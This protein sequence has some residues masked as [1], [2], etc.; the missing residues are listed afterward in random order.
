VIAAANRVA[1]LFAWRML[2][3]ELGQFIRQELFQDPPFVFVLLILQELTKAADVLADDPILEHAFPRL[4]ESQFDLQFR[5]RLGPDE[6]RIPPVC[7]GSKANA[8]QCHRSGCGTFP[9][10]CQCIRRPRKEAEVVNQ[11]K[12]HIRPDIHIRGVRGWPSAHGM[13]APELALSPTEK[14]GL[15]KFAELIEY[16]TKGSP[17]FRQGDPAH[18]LYVL[19][20]GVVRTFTVLANGERQILAF[21]WPGDLFGLAEHN[22]FVNSAE[23]IVPCA[24]YRLPLSKLAAFLQ[25]NP[26]LQEAF[27]VKAFH[28]LRNTQRQ[29]I[30]MGRLN[31]PHRLAAFLLDCSGHEQYYQAS[32]HT[33]SVPI[34][35]YDIADYL[36]ASAETVSRAFG[37]L[38]KGRFIRRGVAKSIVLDTKRIKAFIGF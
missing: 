28:E 13:E 9:D 1:L 35:R 23:A 31:V 12:R 2:W 6:A 15:A 29:L 8:D 21:H 25:A 7:A 14:A 16:K 32:R 10:K 11:N 27:L 33:L 5:V 18:Y 36:G 38:E 20:D 17:I 26:N 22:K 19:A 37:Q 34:T 3:R 4:E 30:V 24:V